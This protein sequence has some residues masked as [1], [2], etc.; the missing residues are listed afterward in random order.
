[1]KIISPLTSIIFNS[2]FSKYHLFFFLIAVSNQ[3][4]GQDASTKIKKSDTQIALE[5]HVITLA[6]K[7]HAG[8]ASYE[9]GIKLSAEYIIKE[10]KKSG[11]QPLPQI[12][13]FRQEFEVINQISLRQTSIFELIN[14]VTK[15]KT[16]LANHCKS[17][18]FTEDMKI[19]NKEIAFV[20][21][22][23]TNKKYD[24]YDNIDVRGKIALMLRLS[25]DFLLD[26]NDVEKEALSIELKLKLAKKNGAIGVILINSPD[27]E[28]I[29]LS[30]K[31]VSLSIG[32]FS[33]RFHLSKIPMIHFKNKALDAI[34]KQSKV[35]L[36]EIQ[37]KINLTDKPNSFI[38]KNIK[39][40]MNLK[41]QMNTYK[42]NNIVAF[43]P[44]ND[45]IL[46]KEAIVIGA[47]YDHVGLG[48]MGSLLGESGHD[49]LHP[50]ADDNASGTAAIVEIA[51]YLKKKQAH[52]K[53]SIIFILFSAEEVGLLGSNYFIKKY[54]AKNRKIVAMINLDMIGN[55][56][57]KQTL[58]INGIA[59][60]EIF[61]PLI[62]KANTGKIK[63]S[64]SLYS[65]W[66]GY[67]DHQAFF[68][69]DIPAIALFT[70]F[71]VNYHRPSDVPSNIN[72]S[73][74]NDIVSILN[75]FIFS[76]ANKSSSISL[77]KNHT[78]NPT[79]SVLNI[80]FIGN[81][82]GFVSKDSPEAKAGIKVN[83]VLLEVDY[84]KVNRY[85]DYCCIIRDRAEGE[86]MQMK[87]K[88][89]VPVKKEIKTKDGSNIKI[90]YVI[91]EMEFLIKL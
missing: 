65:P 35:S 29:Y 24:D 59:S 30:K 36:K 46:S 90:E 89:V 41:Y 9:D 33:L 27:G 52:L 69:N 76:L 84:V 81:F 63:I 18:F 4:Y 26:F 42:T 1:M 85:Y 48:K 11:L 54:R 55:Y 10:L 64:Y 37:N 51:K 87:I 39:L 77:N 61:K 28:G 53:R 21:Y 12:K 86:E 62:E 68:R 14:T 88:R 20:G 47:H 5:K 74:L 79:A 66:Y 71:S 73:G 34:E 19:E 43:L 32:W 83:D 72:F 60:S 8:R 82:I 58:R 38:F 6:S 7:E 13:T 25:P 16:I 45:P 22:G 91:K 40:S 80:A 31:F 75:K 67:T 70:G 17:V 23:I 3:S 15:K 50:G 56:N 44:G 49:K 57:K 78:Y 2:L